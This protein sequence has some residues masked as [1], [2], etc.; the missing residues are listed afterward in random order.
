MKNLLHFPYR[1]GSRQSF[2]IIAATSPY[3]RELGRLLLD[4]REIAV[5]SRECKDS[6]E[7]MAKVFQNWIKRGD[8]V[9]WEK[10]IS[11]LKESR[12]NVLADKL[13]KSLRDSGGP[14]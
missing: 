12:L 9:S 11:S 3:Y 6:N 10:L 14:D 13:A 4:D 5:I 7:A 2:N 8:G 1:I